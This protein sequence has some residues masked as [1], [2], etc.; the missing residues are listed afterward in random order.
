[1]KASGSVLIV[2]LGLLAILAVVGITFITM[3]SLDRRTAT[4]F[5]V[6]SQFILAADG[7]VDYV[8][9][10]LVTDIWAYDTRSLRYSNFL[11]DDH[12]MH[13]ART[14]GTTTNEPFDYPGKG[15]NDEE[16]DPWL[17]TNAEGESLPA[18]G[19]FSFGYQ[20]ASAFRPAYVYGLSFWGLDTPQDQRPNNLGIPGRG[21]EVGIYTSSGAGHGVWIPDLSFPFENGLVRV[22]VT[23]QDHGGMIN[24]NAHGPPPGT[25]QRLGYFISDVDPSKIPGLGTMSTAFF[26]A[27]GDP[28]GLWANPDAPGNRN[29]RQVVIE[30]PG[31]YH[32]RPFTLD[33]ELE[34]RRPTGTFF[35]SRL[36]RFFPGLP[37]DP[38]T[39]SQ[40]RAAVRLSVTT[41]SWTADVR[42]DPRNWGVHPPDEGGVTGYRNRKID[43]NLDEPSDIANAFV[44]N[45]VFSSSE[46]EVAA[47]L[48]AN[49]CAFRDGSEE[50]SG[51]KVYNINIVGGGPVGAGRSFRKVGAAP[52]PIITEVSVTGKEVETDQAGN[53]ETIYTIKATIETPWP[54]DRLGDTDGLDLEGIRLVAEGADGQFEDLPPVIQLNQKIDK[55][56]TVRVNGSNP[57]GTKL[58]YI[59]L[60]ANVDGTNVVLDEVPRT[61]INTQLTDQ[62]KTIYRYWDAENEER[63]PGDPHPIRVV[64]IAQ[65]GE[66]EWYTNK[67]GSRPQGAIPIRFP[68]SVKVDINLMGPP[69][70]G[71]PPYWMDGVSETYGFRA[72]PRLGDLNQVLCPRDNSDAQDFWPW[73]PRVASKRD[74]EEAYVKFNWHDT[75]LPGPGVPSRLNAANVFCVGGP[76]YD[77]I[78]NDGD[79]YIDVDGGGNRVMSRGQ[80]E[81]VYPSASTTGRQRGGRFGG[82]EIRV[83]GLINLNTAT[84]DVLRAL[85]QTFQIP[86]LT[87]AVQRERGMGPLRS[88]A[89]ILRNPTPIPGQEAKGWIERRDLMFTRISNIATIRSDTYSIYGT[90]QY[91][92]PQAL[93][94]ANT[95]EERMAA[96]R[97]SRRFWALVDR[98]PVLCASPGQYGSVE[99]FYRP[100]VLN[101]QWM[102]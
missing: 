76:W 62:G 18:G 82:S 40:S 8:C 56:C 2:V 31:R 47:Q 22:S 43:L 70:G 46:M 92:D 81:G 39:A 44:V 79:G 52:Q 95:V 85:E 10:H 66:T 77:R 17:A 49:I 4:N 23:V 45:N 58:E 69:E 27:S 30:N 80:D 73:V 84:T 7:A 87:Q 34:L 94:D 101:F 12:T 90:V 37:S 68:R 35:T 97:H 3:S 42:P 100:R 55:T 36:E 60:E 86:G 14:V 48:T 24:L 9:H 67:P 64:Y 15:P 21:G 16:F 88:A 29:Q 6:Q 78:D 71:L 83:A 25:S 1:M 13:S 41:V 33:E 75:R 5:A 54:G 91:V 63:F 98:S 96:V 28:P 99:E 59:R 61:V 89:Q 65:P 93:R 26:S 50:G 32:D 11:L 51:L 72:F 38:T 74:S 53:Q 102:D 19:H 20:R 57:P